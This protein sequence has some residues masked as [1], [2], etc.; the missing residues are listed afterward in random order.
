M[1]TNWRFFLEDIR[2]N[3]GDEQ[4]MQHQNQFWM[5]VS[6]MAEIMAE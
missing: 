6:Q 4:D 3:Y 1:P 5:E 2:N